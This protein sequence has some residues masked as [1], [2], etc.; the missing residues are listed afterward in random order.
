LYRSE[1]VVQRQQRSDIEELRAI[2]SDIKDYSDALSSR[3]SLSTLLQIVPII[4]TLSA[5]FGLRISLPEVLAQASFVET[6]VVTIAGWVAAGHLLLGL[7]LSP[8]IAAFHLKRLMLENSITQRIQDLEF[9]TEPEAVLFD[10]SVYQV[11]NRLYQLLGGGTDQQ[12]PKEIP[13][14]IY[15]RIGFGLFVIAVT[16]SPMVIVVASSLLQSNNNADGA[17]NNEDDAFLSRID[18]VL[19]S[20]VLTGSI[21]V[22]S[23]IMA[24]IHRRRSRLL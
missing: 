23:P 15:L 8:L 5:I 10:R 2:A 21:Y 16:F 24:Y 17:N 1:L 18:Y 6:I 4:A 3:R 11:E 14:D 13:F 12:K 7:T 22:L 19:G 20:L 9:R